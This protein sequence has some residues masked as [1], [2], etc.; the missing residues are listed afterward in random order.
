MKCAWRYIISGER[1]DDDASDDS[2]RENS[3][4]HSLAVQYS[5][6]DLT[7]PSASSN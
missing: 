2:R 4:K 1:V 5:E 3:I 7:R 6:L